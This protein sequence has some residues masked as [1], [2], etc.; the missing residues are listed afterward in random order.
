M[1]LPSTSL[2][3][4]LGGHEWVTFPTLNS[5]FWGLEQ[6]LALKQYLGTAIKVST[7][8]CRFEGVTEY[9]E[10]GNWIS[11]CVNALLSFKD[12]SML[13]VNFL[14]GLRRFFHD[15]NYLISITAK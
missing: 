3:P 13:A 4:E 2:F 8:I 9:H 12:F 5:L 11:S 14:I 7:A 6:S 10:N 15:S 1:C